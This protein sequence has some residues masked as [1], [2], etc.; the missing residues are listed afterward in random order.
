MLPKDYKG[1]VY[2]IIRPTGLLDPIVEIR[3]IFPENFEDLKK[4]LELYGYD[5]M[6]IYK[7]NKED[8]KSQVQDVLLEINLVLQK[9]QRV[10]VITLT[11]KMSEELSEYLVNK[12]INCKYIHS[13]IDT[14]ERVDLLRDLR[15]GVYDVLVGINLLRE[16]LDLPEV[17]LIAILDADKEGFLRSKT[18][19]IQIIGRAAR[20]EEGR[21]IMYAD[22]ITKSIKEAI[23]ETRKRRKIQEEYNI[24][25]GITPKSIK[26]DII[27]QLEKFREQNEEINQNKSDLIKLA[28]SYK[29]MNKKE[30]QK[31]KKELKLQMQI[32]ADLLEFEKAAEIRDILTNL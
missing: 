12:G 16:G 3:P 9:K 7:K 20:H 27:D 18:S 1:I 6:P 13:D 4:D 17:S 32:Y 31:L 22:K 23:D 15:K 5:D 11:K 26:K 10:L 28:E 30:K 2:Q 19:L 24:K 29:T 14:V 8:I 21:V 25:N